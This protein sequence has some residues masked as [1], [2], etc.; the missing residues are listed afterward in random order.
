MRRLIADRHNLR[1]EDANVHY[2]AMAK[3]LDKLTIRPTSLHF[4]D[5]QS[6][7]SMEAIYPWEGMYRA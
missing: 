3:H 5:G 7:L 4:D 1:R 6:E 2:E